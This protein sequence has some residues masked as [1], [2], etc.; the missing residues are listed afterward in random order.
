VLVFSES[1]EAMTPDERQA[2]REKHRQDF[3]D[4]SD[5]HWFGCLGCIK[6]GAYIEWPCD[7]I[8]VLD[9]WEQDLDELEWMSD[10][11]D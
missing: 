7:V 3:C 4:C 10:G 2:L 8:K 9:A 11:V 5:E 6:D 1:G